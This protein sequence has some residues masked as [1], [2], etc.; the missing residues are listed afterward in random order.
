MPERRR[1]G[2]LV[3]LQRR[4]DG[5]AVVLTRRADDLPT[6]AGQIS[7][8]GGRHDP[9]LDESLLATALRE[10]DE[11]IGLR[12]SDVVVIGALP[13]VQTRSSRFEIHPFVGQVPAVYD[14][15]PHAGEVVEVFAMPLRTYLDPTCRVAH[16]WTLDGNPIEVPAVSFEGRVVWGATLRILDLLR[17]SGLLR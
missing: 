16:T 11:E 3:P 9:V 12:P 5:L 15:N 10:A 13:T 6:H 17:D 4:G 2:V 8:P 7:F 1:A 14:F